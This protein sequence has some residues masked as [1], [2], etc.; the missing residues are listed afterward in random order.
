MFA[1]LFPVAAALAAIAM[2]EP[3]NVAQQPER[4]FVAVSA[5]PA[6]AA[7]AQTAIVEHAVAALPDRFQDARRLRGSE[8]QHVLPGMRAIREPGQSLYRGV[9]EEQFGSRPGTH[10][11][12]LRSR[13]AFY[14]LRIFYDLHIGGGSY[15]LRDD[16]VC[17]VVVP[18]T[19]E[20]CRGVFRLPNGRYALSS[21][22]DPNQPIVAIRLE[23][24]SNG[25]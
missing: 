13:G 23:P 14:A 22:E 4:D 25:R 3:P 21:Y 24:I 12:T 11:R 2:T 1:F 10:A 5:L 15:R 20:H 17:T 16:E 19:V 6:A 18:D 9:E 7:T 8:L